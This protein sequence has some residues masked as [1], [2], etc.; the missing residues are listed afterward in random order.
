MPHPDRHTFWRGHIKAFEEHGH[1]QHAYCRDHGI[2][3][4][5]FRKWRTR[6]VGPV[7]PSPAEVARD[8]QAPEHGLSEFAYPALAA[9]EVPPPGTTDVVGHI[10]RRRRWTDDEK[11]QL[12]WDGLN[13]GQS[14]SQYA[15]R[16]HIH[17]SVMHRWL[18]TLTRP[19]LAEPPSAEPAFA[20]V[21]IA[22]PLTT[23]RA[24]PGA[25]SP[26][27]GELSTCAIE[28]LLANGRLVRVGA[29]VDPDALRRVIAVLESVT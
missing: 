29:G 15:K 24:L 26:A 3:A 7:R 14:L 11:R 2:S 17:P 20:D 13:S 21:R 27:W 19:V 12:V 4:R 8:P 9:Q 18:C 25:A 22:E 1:S 23:V 28:I 5:Q 16:L 10:V 6:L